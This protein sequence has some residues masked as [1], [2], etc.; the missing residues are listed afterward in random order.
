MK[1]DSEYQLSNLS[2]MRIIGYGLVFLSILDIIYIIYP[3]NLLNPTWEF[4]TIGA[5]VEHTPVSLLALILVFYGKGEFRLQTEMY[6]LKFIS[7]FCLLVGLLFV[8]IIPLG[9]INTYRLYYNGPAIA[10]SNQQI[11]Q[12]K[13]AKEKIETAKSTEEITKLLNLPQLPQNAPNIPDLKQLKTQT[14][15][16]LNQLEKN[17]KQQS[18]QV[19]ENQRLNLLKNSVK[20]NLGALVVAILFFWIWKSTVWVRIAVI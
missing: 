18:E 2:V 5:L 1:F 19:I 12:I 16:N 3:P 8:L 9:L 17:I 13:T 15:T 10:Q 6:L 7:W 11:Q 14:L 4:N 20:W